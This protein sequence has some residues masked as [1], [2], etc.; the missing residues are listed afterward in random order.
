MALRGSPR[1]KDVKK[2]SYYV[3]FLGAKESRGLRGEEYVRPVVRH[4]LQ[5]ERDVEPFK[6]T[7]QV[8]NKGLKIIQNVPGKGAAVTGK[9]GS[10]G[11]SGGKAGSGSSGDV[12]KHFIPHHA[13]TCAVQ[14][15][16][17]NEDVVSAI[18]L[19]YNP[20]TRCPVHVH[21]YRCDSVETATILRSQLQTLIERPENQRK[22]AEI[23]SRLHAKGLLIPPGSPQRVGSPGEPPITIGSPTGGLH[24]HNQSNG[25][26]NHGGGSDG[27]SSST[28]ESESSGSSERGNGHPA[29]PPGGGVGGNADRITSLYDSLAAELRE[30]LGEVGSGG[31]GKKRHG[32][33]LLPPRDYDTVHR[34]H[35]NLTGIDLRRCLNANI[36]GVNARSPAAPLGSS[37]AVAASGKKGV[38]GPGS[39]SAHGAGYTLQQ[40][41]SSGGSSGIGSDDAPSPEND[42]ESSDPRYLDNQSSSDEEWN[43][44]SGQ[45][46]AMSE[47]SMFL[48]QPT[49]H[50]KVTQQPPRQQPQQP[51]RPLS[52]DLSLPRARR[53]LSGGSDS[54]PSSNAPAYPPGPPSD[55]NPPRRRRPE[56]RQR[57]P[58]PGLGPVVGGPLSPRE[59][60]QDAKEKFLLLERQRIEE[61]GR[62][63]QKRREKERL[64]SPR[65][66]SSHGGMPSPS[67]RNSSGQPQRGPRPTPREPRHSR[68]RE[69]WA[70]EEEYEDEDLG[71]NYEEEPEED[72]ESERIRRV[73]ARRPP[74]PPLHRLPSPPP[75]DDLEDPDI[76]EEEVFERVSGGYFGPRRAPEYR[77]SRESLL[78]TPPEEVVGHRG[79]SRSSGGRYPPSGPALPSPNH[80]HNHH[81]ASPPRHPNLPPHLLQQQQADKKRRS[82]FD[83]V[84]EERRR[85]SN[86]LAKEFKRRSYHEPD[87][88]EEVRRGGGRRSGGPPPPSSGPGGNYHELAEH[89]RYPGLDRETA[90]LNHLHAKAHR[91]PSEGTA[92]GGGGRYR[93]SYAEPEMFHHRGSGRMGMA[94]IHPY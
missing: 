65:G 6:V 4:L 34:K 83:V 21:S 87:I 22:F 35:G 80:H 61:Q 85:N 31:G 14:D 50:P 78:D 88:A 57:S 45:P 10:S 3:W 58:S 91:T 54:A 32:P 39:G 60:F 74:P 33:I 49:W 59:R 2:S 94:A 25:R 72:E 15:S 84:E 86:E 9:V 7:L 19:I 1:R 16:P 73:R 90:R 13:V 8:S 47:D 38:G 29:S 76:L 82:M 37:A 53:L 28:R 63:V 36:V 75:D 81:P 62:L 89:E 52:R 20:V 24:H 41:G 23:E 43:E 26:R 77:R 44:R 11:A 71:E 55:A 48:V 40:G 66:S 93:H 64:G 5:K 18:L 70:S 67:P 27:R 92:V 68:G 79:V 69:E 12:V 46:S 42:R 56:E 51:Q 30:K 17:P